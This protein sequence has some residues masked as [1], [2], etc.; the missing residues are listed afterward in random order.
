MPTNPYHCLPFVA[1]LL[2]ASVETRAETKPQEAF[3]AEYCA[4]CHG[5]KKQENDL[6][7]DRLSELPKDKL[8]QV[9]HQVHQKLATDEMPPEDAKQPDAKSRQR[10][11]AWI[12]KNFGKPEPRVHWAFQSIVRPKVPDE[13]SAHHA[14][15]A[16]V[17]A[18]L[19]QQGLIA[20]PPANRRTLIRR[21]TLD[22][23]GLPPTPEEVQ[24]FVNDPA[25]FD[26][27]FARVVDRL[28]YSPRYGERWAQHWLDVIRWAETVGFETNFERPNAWH[29]RDWVINALN[30]DKPYDRF[31]FEQI[32][33]DTVSADAALGFLVA[34][35]ANLPGQIGRDEEAMRQARQDE[36]D[37]VIR[38]VSQ[39]LFGLTIGCARCHD[40]KFDPIRQRDYYALQAIFAGLSYGDRR[41][42]GKQNDEWT[43]HVPSVRE[44]LK[45][46]LCELEDV[47][48]RHQLRPPLESIHTESFGPVSVDAVRMEFASTGGGP[49]S[50]Y[51]FEIWSA[52]GDETPSKN[53]ALASSGGR[54][55]ASS[56][57]LANQT[58]HYDNLVDG[59]VDKRQAFPWVAATG[60]PAWLQIDLATPTTI[61]RV[62]WHAGSS[63]P[64][65]YTIQGRDPR[66]DGWKTLA[67][68]RDRQPRTSD[69]R[70]AKD[71]DIDGMSAKQIE[72]LCKLLSEIRAAQSDLTR[73]TNGPQTYAA[74]FNEMPETTWLLNRGDPLQRSEEVSP[75]VPAVL[76]ERPLKPPP[77]REV[78]RRLALVR[79][80]TRR[81]HP[82]T[83]RVMVNRVWQHHFGIGL[84]ET[85]S[86]FGKMGAA[87]SHPRL[88]DWLAVEFVS[89][90][91][92]LKQLHR[93]IVTSRTY[94]QSSLPRDE[95]LAIDAESRLLWRYPP[96]RLDAEAIRDSILAASGK[97]NKKRYGAGFD[98]FD[99]RG[100]L[101]D[102]TPK[103]TFEASGWRRMI[104]AHKIRMES[105]D[106]FGAFDCPD[107]GQMTPRRNLSI[108]PIQSLGLFNSPFTNRH[109][110]FF[111]ERI[112]AEAPKDEKQQVEQAFEIALARPPSTAESQRMLQLAKTHGLEQVCRVLLNCSEF[113]F[114]Q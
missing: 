111:A 73:L 88:L 98:F 4:S 80:L 35:P 67:H 49:A 61:D 10:M 31:I 50:L 56:F 9:W 84:V 74:R 6:R 83:A 30:E 109:A 104:Y 99:R 39:S 2:A 45:Q 101:S 81:D 75:A 86:D 87:P 7:F 82:L 23:I 108:T 36:L 54:P 106:I 66:T 53:V 19:R 14:I 77:E 18:K 96:R 72:V 34:G 71:V 57:A 40:H 24:V 90:G 48:L 89:R 5:A 65:S 20:S 1:L 38:T 17:Q 28:L 103:E 95:A 59:T 78:D 43:A 97:L 42:R 13:S 51:E 94:Q 41:L 16:F 15:D 25:Q 105:V 11:L 107:A 91:W 68:T 79:H 70:A 93:L 52:A 8:R 100:G 64:A 29:Y 12:T 3:L 26:K 102:Y 114:L 27:A 55:S 112:R 22:L 63:I 62:V 47:R 92:S 33:G 60:G 76:V 46:L 44:K 85:P 21:V 32:A 37:E 69:T 58:R 110:G 113:V